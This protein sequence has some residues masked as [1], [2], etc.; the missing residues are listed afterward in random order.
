MIYVYIC[1]KICMF[2]QVWDRDANRDNSTVE[3]ISVLASGVGDFEVLLLTETAVDSSV[4][5]GYIP[6]IRI[7]NPGT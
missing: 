6:G 5:T 1:D 7:P 3:S 2:C 4:Y